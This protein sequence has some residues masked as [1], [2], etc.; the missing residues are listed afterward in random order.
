MVDFH[1]C[2]HPL[3]FFFVLANNSLPFVLRHLERGGSPSLIV[4]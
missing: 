2:P 4:S 1:G 3:L